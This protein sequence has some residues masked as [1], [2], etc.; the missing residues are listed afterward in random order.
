MVRVHPSESA[1]TCSVLDIFVKTDVV[2]AGVAVRAASTGRVLMLQRAADLADPAGGTWEFPGGHLEAGE[3]PQDAARREWEEETGIPLPDGELVGSKRSGVYECFV[4]EIPD[5]SNLSLNLFAGDRPISNPDDPD[6][7]ALEGA[8]WKSP[9]QLRSMPDLRPELRD[10]LP[11]TWVAKADDTGGAASPEEVEALLAAQAESVTPPG[12]TIEED[13]A[14]A[15]AALAD[16]ESPEASAQIPDPPAEI[17]K[18]GPVTLHLHVAGVHRD[19]AK[20]RYRMASRDGQYVGATLPTTVRA[21]KGDVLV[22][23]PN[24]FGRNEQGDF[25][26]TNPN[27]AGRHTGR[28]MGRRVLEA[29]AGGDLEK[30][31]AGATSTG[32]TAGSVHVDAPLSNLSVS[33]AGKRRRLTK[34]GI[35]EPAKQLIYG[36]VLEPNTVDSQGDMVSPEAI[37]QAAHSYLAKAAQG[38]ST[39]HREQHGPA[40]FSPSNP[41]MVPV[42]SFIAPCDFSYDGREQIR[43]GSWVL[44]SHVLDRKLWKRILRGYTDGEVGQALTGWSVGGSGRR[45][46]LSAMLVAK[47]DEPSQDDR[48]DL[49]ALTE[50]IVKLAERPQPPIHVESPVTI[51]EGAIQVSP[52]AVHVAP[53]EVHYAEGAIQVAAPTVHVE[54]PR[55]RSVRAET[56]PDGSRRYSPEP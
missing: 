39:V 55:A 24:L 43:K 17:E 41:K 30:D 46:P 35:A 54:Q 52:A 14:Q 25:T 34:A 19:G 9:E 22:V 50:A 42:E 11:W 4:Y 18:R 49:R 5:E 44:V 16:H 28:A 38:R 27:V 13:E 21:V 33:Y 26:W 8:G 48:G 6:G 20:H 29:L 12:Q 3:R 37:E 47:D 15:I 2:A 7:D 53:A 45:R 40:L 36:I 32:P 1:D 56:L 51:A 10:S 31:D 23:E